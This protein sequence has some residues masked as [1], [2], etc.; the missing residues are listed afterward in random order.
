MAAAWM[1]GRWRRLT[2][3]D[4]HG[5]LS[6]FEDSFTLGEVGILLGRG[7][8]RAGGFLFVVTC[9]Q[10]DSDWHPQFANV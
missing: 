4:A 1:R 7:G 3:I 8:R 5:R 9:L 6:Y 2:R 10:K